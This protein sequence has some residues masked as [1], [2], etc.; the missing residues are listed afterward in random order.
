[1][2]LTSDKV[3][4]DL[5]RSIQ[6]KK[7]KRRQALR[8]TLLTRPGDADYP[9]WVIMWYMPAAKGNGGSGHRIYGRAKQN[10][11]KDKFKAIE[12][13]NEYLRTRPAL[14]G[15]TLEIE[16]EIEFYEELASARKA[17]ITMDEE[18]E[19]EAFRAS[20]M[21]IPDNP[22]STDRKTPTSQDRDPD[23]EIDPLE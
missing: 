22:E 20:N 5:Q 17:R 14:E 10:I 8:I 12:Q 9:S 13:V 3:R 7:P 19:L 16:H 6:G 2:E 15:C 23:E 1:M 11:F 4:A 18:R 21:T